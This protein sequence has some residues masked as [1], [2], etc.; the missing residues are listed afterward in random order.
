MPWGEQRDILSGIY[1]KYQNDPEALRKD[2]VDDYN[3]NNTRGDFPLKYDC[4]NVILG[5]IQK[6][7]DE[8]EE[9]RREMETLKRKESFLQEYKKEIEKQLN[10][11]SSNYP[12]VTT[13][14]WDGKIK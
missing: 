6:R 14:Y 8:L 10:W 1:D 9:V 12:D 2:V 7:K 13:M 11:V 5:E 4:Y 3:K